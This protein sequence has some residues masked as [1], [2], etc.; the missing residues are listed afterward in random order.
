MGGKPN[1]N[2]NWSPEFESFAR[3]VIKNRRKTM[4]VQQYRTDAVVVSRSWKPAC[5]HQATQRGRIGG[6][7]SAKSLNNLVFKLNNCDVPMQSMITITMA[8]EVSRRNSVEFHQATLKAALQKLRRDGVNQYC[9]VREFQKNGSVHW[10]IFTDLVVGAA[11]EVNRE[12]STLWQWWMVDRYRQGWINQRCIDDMTS[13]GKDGFVGCI[14][15]EQLHG[16]IGGRYAGKE[17]SKRFQ[18]I[19]PKR[20]R[21]GGAWWRASRNVQCTPEGIKRLSVEA[22][23]HAEIK[24]N[25]KTRHIPYRVQFNRGTN[26][27]GRKDK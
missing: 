21:D 4:D 2:G 5:A 22:L 3:E 27:T 14:R 20:W 8:D 19:A 7:P 23:E 15:V 11:G 9:W 6:R 24:I 1:L 10:H 16:D 26:P 12:L 25:G 17:G 18:K 13:P